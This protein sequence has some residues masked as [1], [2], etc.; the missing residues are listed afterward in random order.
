MTYGEL[1]QLR[2]ALLGYYQD[3]NIKV[4]LFLREGIQ[5]N[6]GKFALPFIDDLTEPFSKPGV[7]RNLKTG[8]ATEFSVSSSLKVIARK[9]GTNIGDPRGTKLGLNM[10]NPANCVF[11]EK[12]SVTPPEKPGSADEFAFSAR[13]DSTISD[14]SGKDLNLDSQLGLM[15]KLLGTSEPTNDNA[16]QVVTLDLFNKKKDE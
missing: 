7:I 5:T 11:G 13:S 8:R 10:Y 4:A 9:R 6:N 12:K 14:S 16:N 15:L 3:V 2:F 1:T